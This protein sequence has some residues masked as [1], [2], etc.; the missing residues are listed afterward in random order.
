MAW[1]SCWSQTRRWL[2]RGTGWMERMWQRDDRKARRHRAGERRW[3]WIW[4]GCDA[5]DAEISDLVRQVHEEIVRLPTPLGIDD[6][7]LTVRA[8]GPRRDGQDES[9]LL[10]A[11]QAGDEEAV[12]ADLAQRDA[13][14]IVAVGDRTRGH[15]VDQRSWMAGG[16]R[17]QLRQILEL[18]RPSRRWRIVQV[19]LFSVGEAY[20]KLAPK[21][22]ARN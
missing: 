8:W 21:T 9:V 2:G 13:P 11:R 20:L 7:I 15:I 17:E 18:C 14:T 3:T 6:F 19:S 1:A 5:T 16:V 10:A 22:L 4:V 12:R